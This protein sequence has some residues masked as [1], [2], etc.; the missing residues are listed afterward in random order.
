MSEAFDKKTKRCEAAGLVIGEHHQRL[1]DEPF[2]RY[3]VIEGLE[4][5]HTKGGYEDKEPLFPFDPATKYL[6]H[7]IDLV[8]L[9]A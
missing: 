8:E 1:L 4:G 6:W 5:L 3:K 9:G 2:E 7:D